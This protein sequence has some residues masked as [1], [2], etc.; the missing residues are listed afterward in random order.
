MGARI[1]RILVPVDFSPCSD[2]ALSYATSL[3]QK[4]GAAVD[5][6]HVW[7]PPARLE[8]WQPA[9]F[10]RFMQ[11]SLDEHRTELERLVGPLREEG[12][13]M[14]HKVVADTAVPGIV[15]EADTGNYDLIVLGTH[16]RTGLRRVLLGSVA[17]AVVR[18]ARCPV[19]TV[20][21]GHAAR[22]RAA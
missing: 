2:S 20:Q 21:T 7:E 13:P 9:E 6:L 1:E 19:L 17:E 16:G 22:T 4:L 12:I 3:A 5:V 8:P 10:D 15:H 14:R 11:G 18:H